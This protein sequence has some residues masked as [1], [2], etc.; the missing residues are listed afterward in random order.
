MLAVDARSQRC[1]L[2]MRGQ[3]RWSHPW[4]CAS[5]PTSAS[6]RSS[7]VVSG[8]AVVDVDADGHLVVR[9]LPE[10]LRGAA[11][12]GWPWSRR[13][14]QFSR[15]R[16][17]SRTAW[18]VVIRA[19]VSGPIRRRSRVAILRVARPAS[20]PQSDGPRASAPSRPRRAPPNGSVASLADDAWSMVCQRLG[21]VRDD[22]RGPRSRAARP[23]RPKRGRS[24]TPD[25]RVRRDP[26]LAG[27]I[28]RREGCRAGASR[29]GPSPRRP[30][31]RRWRRNSPRC[32][33]P[34]ASSLLR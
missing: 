1:E 13:S 25:Q 7:S 26:D 31:V 18:T 29:S 22:R 28:G 19:S 20:P 16:P 27:S 34:S 21:Q 32:L 23:V 12:S 15:D 5:R 8:C 10:R 14:R 24:P 11:A 9:R 17:R 30:R 33:P 6:R 2:V 4:S 3:G